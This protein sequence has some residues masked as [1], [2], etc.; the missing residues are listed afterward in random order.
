MLAQLLVL[1]SLSSTNAWLSSPSR[2]MAP[3]HVYRR[4]ADHQCLL[5]RYSVDEN[6][7]Y[8]DAVYSDDDDLDAP[9]DSFE[10]SS[11]EPRLSDEELEAASGDWDEKVARFNTIHLTGRVG[12]DPEPRYLDNGKVV[13][14]LSLAT[15]RKYHSLERQAYDIKWGQEETDWYGLEIW[16]STAEFVSK[17]VDKGARVGVVGTLQID[18]W[19]DRETNEPRNRVKVVVRDLDILE[20]RDEAQARRSRSGG[21]GNYKQNNNQYGNNK[22]QGGNSYS[23]DED[24]W[25]SP[26]GSGDFF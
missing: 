5:I 4:I 11:S 19:T 1:A 8:A 6:D 13:V 9:F 25:P 18:D 26:A 7:D 2:L 10:S 22:R 23:D 16:G 14:N 3:L 20:T 12:N 15:R 24:E 21:R 17:Y